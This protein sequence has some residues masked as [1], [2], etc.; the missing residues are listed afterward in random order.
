M[1]RWTCICKVLAT[2]NTEFETLEQEEHPIGWDS[3]YSGCGYSLVNT[4]WPASRSILFSK[5]SFT[6]SPLQVVS[7]FLLLVEPLPFLDFRSLVLEQSI[8][9]RPRLIDFLVRLG[10]LPGVVLSSM[11]L[12]TSLLLSKSLDRLIQQSGLVGTTVS[13]SLAEHAIVPMLFET[14][15]IKISKQCL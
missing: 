3:K 11:K 10:L 5:R 14:S 4:I 6:S 7:I 13:S 15:S 12:E 8:G 2:G 1:G 9:C